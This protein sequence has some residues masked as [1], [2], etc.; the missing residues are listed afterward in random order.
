MIATALFF[1]AIG[2][3]YAWSRRSAREERG[4]ESADARVLFIGNSFTFQNDLPSMLR[5]LAKAN[6]FRLATQMI[7]PPGAL[8]ESQAAD[9]EVHRRLASRWTSVVLQEQSQQASFL[10]AQSEKTIAALLSLRRRAAE[11][12]NTTVLFET[13]GYRDGDQ[14]NIP[15]DTFE[16]MASR[17]ERG[18]ATFSE[19]SGIALVPVGHAW[20]RA[21]R[22]HPDVV[23]WAGDGK[24][25][26]VAGT[27]LAACV[28]FVTLFHRS[29]VG[30]AYV[31][32]LPA[33]EAR[34]LQQIAAA[35]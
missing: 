28:F 12:G 19:K 3:L 14:S 25:P 1:A 31:A 20:A 5:E 9:P 27:Y 26:T 21:H 2:G 17:L 24:H 8:L 10:P 13:W 18:Y 34:T 4:D 11:A 15:N 22:E 16:A 23:L 32:N 6:D 30:N 35:P 29:P 33:K 7:A